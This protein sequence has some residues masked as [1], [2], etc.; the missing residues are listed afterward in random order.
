MTTGTV[1]DPFGHRWSIS[2]V[3]EEVSPDEMQRRTA[4]MGPSTT[5]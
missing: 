1:V 4:G 3:V 5:P 2:A